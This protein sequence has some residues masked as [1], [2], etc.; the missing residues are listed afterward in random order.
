MLVVH[1]MLAPPG[2]AVEAQDAHLKNWDM[3]SLA[4]GETR[5]RR[6]DLIKAL[7][8]VPSRRPIQRAI[9]PFALE[10]DRFARVEVKGV[11]VRLIS[12]AALSRDGALGGFPTCYGVDRA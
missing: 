2:L 4:R 9:V 1:L 7:V 5:E 10:E 12:A 6:C 3:P 11:A 8:S